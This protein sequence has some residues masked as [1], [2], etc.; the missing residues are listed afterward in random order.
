[1]IY[2]A[3]D[4]ETVAGQVESLGCWELVRPV[5]VTKLFFKQQ[6]DSSSGGDC[7]ATEGE[8]RKDNVHYQP[9]TSVRRAH[10]HGLCFCG[11]AVS[12]DEE[13]DRRYHQ[14]YGVVDLAEPLE[15]KKE[16]N[17]KPCAGK[18]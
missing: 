7:I 6:K 18:V 3:K 9:G 8:P 4:N 5:E 13:H 1:M 10:R 11:E 2:E 14:A 15:N 12:K 17:G 16:R